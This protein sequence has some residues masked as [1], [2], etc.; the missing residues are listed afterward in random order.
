EIYS[1]DLT[2]LHLNVSSFTPFV[3]N[4][5]LSAMKTVAADQIIEL[6]P[7]LHN[8]HK[9]EMTSFSVLVVGGTLEQ[10]SPVLLQNL[11]NAGVAM[12]DQRGMSNISAVEDFKT[13]DTR[14][15]EALVIHV[16]RDLLSPYMPGRIATGGRFFG[17]IDLLN[18]TVV[19]K[20][21]GNFTFIGNR[22][23]G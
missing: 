20:F 7:T 18:R 16:G 15:A 12:I 1:L 14:L 5:R 3:V 9:K 17:R 6:L 8:L 19:G 4:K 11:R 13:S 22:R 23:I 10:E 2:R 21:G